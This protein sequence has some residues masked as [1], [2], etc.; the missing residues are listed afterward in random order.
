MNARTAQYA[1]LDRSAVRFLLAHREGR[2]E[3]GD[4][5]TG[6]VFAHTVCY[7]P[8]PEGSLLATLSKAPVPMDLIQR[9]GLAMLNVQGM[10]L[11]TDGSLVDEDG[12]ATP[13]AVAHVQVAV[14]IDP[15]TDDQPAGHSQ[16][17]DAGGSP[18][19]RLRIRGLQTWLR[20]IPA[21]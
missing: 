7:E 16:P 3:I 10:D 12:L 19:L 17:D 2:L 20:T 5:V 18:S 13:D 1:L 14:Q 6:D 4:P 21:A 8:G 11:P 15:L 9:H